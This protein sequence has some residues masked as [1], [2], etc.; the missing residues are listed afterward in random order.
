[1]LIHWIAE[2]S[3]DYLVPAVAVV[4]VVAV[5]SEHWMLLEQ[6]DSMPVH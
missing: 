3:V 5:E 1:M 6:I 4:A 2:H